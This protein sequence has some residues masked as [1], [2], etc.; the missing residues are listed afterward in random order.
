MPYETKRQERVPEV[1]AYGQCPPFTGAERSQSMRPVLKKGGA[2][3]NNGHPEQSMP[4][5]EVYALKYAG[6]FTGKLAMMLWLTGWDEEVERAYYVWVIKG[7]DE[8]IVVDAGAGITLAGEKELANYVNPIEVLARIGADASNVK[9]VII[10]HI[11]FDHAGG[12]EMFRSAFPHA[13]FYV[14]QKEFDFWLKD[15]LAMKP[16]LAALSDLH[17]NKILGDLYDSGR[18]TLVDGDRE[19]MP[20]IEL[21]FAPGHTPGLQ[22]V[23]VNTT[24]GKV[25]LASDCAHITRNFHEGRPSCFIFDMAAW[26]R[27]YERLKPLTPVELLFPGHDMAMLTDYPIAAPDITRL[28]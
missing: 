14:Q 16:P 6:P 17:A 13:A 27:T 21:L 24:K 12:V 8:I 11:H 5:Y 9:K 18:V 3:V 4:F 10:T 7:P 28:A 23:A 26:L 2:Q 15:P 1:L 19:I 20:G 22:A 25:I